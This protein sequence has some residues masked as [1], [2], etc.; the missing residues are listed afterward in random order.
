[1]MWNALL[2]WALQ[3]VHISSYLQTSCAVVLL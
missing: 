3:T 1:M 2:F